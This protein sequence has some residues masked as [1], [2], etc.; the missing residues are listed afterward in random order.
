MNIDRF[1]LNLL[2]YLDVLLRERN[3]TKAANIL[4]IS[5]PAMSNG[6]RRLRDLL[7][8]PLL[9]R[10]SEG[11]T[12]TER[13]ENLQPVVRDALSR[14][15]KALQPQTEF[16]AITS[17][18]VFRIMASDYAE[19][20]LIPQLLKEMREIAPNAT[21]D[22]MT[23]SDVSFLDVEQGKVD[24][25]INRFDSI[26]QSFHQKDVWMDSFSCLVS[27]NNP[28]IDDFNLDTYLESNHVWVSKTGWGVGVGIDP[29]D[30]QRLG[31]VDEALD[32]IGKKRRIRVF[33]RHYQAAMLL[34]ERKDLVV[35]IPTRAANLLVN[36]PNIVI[37]APPFDIPPIKLKMAWSP[38]LQHNP[39]HQWFRRLIVEVAEK[40]S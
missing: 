14:L 20:T 13:A 1:D 39:G 37:K 31:W 26:P 10:T 2:V 28:I 22:I 6:L 38:L 4:G 3:V 19:S 40:V 25:V 15:E 32:R 16:D 5:Q 21:L 35:T 17:D 7:E 33:T 34:A 23:P 27:V 18:R 12:P 29:D 24:M 11:M 8:D 9:V 30:V 36:N